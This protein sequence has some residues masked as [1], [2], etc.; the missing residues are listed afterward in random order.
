M[1]NRPYVRCPGPP[2]D[3]V[4]GHIFEGVPE[5]TEATCPECQTVTPVGEG[6]D[7]V[8]LACGRALRVDAA[9]YEA[10]AVP[11]CIGADAVIEYRGPKL[12]RY[13]PTHARSRMV[14][15]AEIPELAASGEA[16]REQNAKVDA[17]NLARAEAIN[18]E[19]RKRLDAEEE[20]KRSAGIE[21]PEPSPTAILGRAVEQI[22][23]DQEERT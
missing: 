7:V 12:R 9:D 8:C 1:P 18:A 23:A 10:G 2:G 22:A 3:H 13:E 20:A 5:R 16:L 17:E 6:V 11:V 4:C 15:A 19:T 14:T 21:E